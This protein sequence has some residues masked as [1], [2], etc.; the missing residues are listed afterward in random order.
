MFESPVSISGEEQL[1]RWLGSLE[2]AGKGVALQREGSRQWLTNT[3]T[4]EW[5]NHLALCFQIENVS[6]WKTIVEAVKK[7]VNGSARVTGGLVELLEPRS[8]GNHQYFVVLIVAPSEIMANIWDKCFGE[9]SQHVSKGFGIWLDALF[10]FGLSVKEAEGLLKKHNGLDAWI[11]YN[12][13]TGIK[14]G[15]DVP[16]STFFF[17]RKHDLFLNTAQPTMKSW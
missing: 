13:V 5:S 10:A 4:G 8:T 12:I 11:F 9:K 6:N 15:D 16:Y 2:C 17:L 1:K 14:H 3:N 7:A